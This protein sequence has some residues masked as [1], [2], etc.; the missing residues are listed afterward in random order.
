MAQQEF[1]HTREEEETQTS[2]KKA[3]RTSP[4]LCLPCNAMSTAKI[5]EPFYT[6]LYSDI[7]VHS[8]NDKDCFARKECITPLRLCALK[9]KRG[10]KARTG[11][12]FYW[13]LLPS[14]IIALISY[15]RVWSGPVPPPPP[16]PPPTFML[17][18]DAFLR[19]LIRSLRLEKELDL[20]ATQV[21]TYPWLHFSPRY[22]AVF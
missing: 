21:K 11:K 7:K 13:D 18:P 9:R 10:Q 14:R 2:L 8:S 1:N 20:A 19:L 5:G 6:S 12:Q 3:H 15:L 16:P 4:R 17:I 22:F